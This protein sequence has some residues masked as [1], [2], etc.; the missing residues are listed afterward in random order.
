MKFSEVSKWLKINIVRYG[1]A[2]PFHGTDG[3]KPFDDDAS[4]QIR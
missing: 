3:N 4:G 1:P 2:G